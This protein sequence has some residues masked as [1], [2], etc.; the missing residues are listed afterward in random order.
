MTLSFVI[1]VID[2]FGGVA[3]F[4]Y[5]CT[6]IRKTIHIKTMNSKLIKLDAPYQV[7]YAGG[8]VGRHIATLM[9]WED[10]KEG[11][12][13][14]IGARQYPVIDQGGEFAAGTLVWEAELEDCR[15]LCPINKEGKPGTNLY[16]FASMV[17]YDFLQE[18]PMGADHM[19]D[20]LKALD[21]TIVLPEDKNRKDEDGNPLPQIDYQIS[22]DILPLKEKDGEEPTY[23]VK[24]NKW[25]GF[26]F[27]SYGTAKEI[28][29]DLQYQR[30][31][32]MEMFHEHL[33]EIK[34]T[35]DDIMLLDDEI[36]K[37]NSEI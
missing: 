10:D 37:L 6:P 23:R 15:V 1:I 16:W 3:D 7:I 21:C 31:C 8:K 35:T 25:C 30:T 19:F 17:E 22:L 36:K 11:D 24:S 26:Y 4:V 2:R 20:R 13:A 5:L 9:T 32:Y 18:E 14:I 29:Y 27:E 34:F 12:A 33:I 28:Y